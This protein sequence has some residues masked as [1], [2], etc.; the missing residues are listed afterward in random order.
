MDKTIVASLKRS[1]IKDK[2][3]K[4]RITLT[5]TE[6][7]VGQRRRHEDSKIEVHYTS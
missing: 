6:T 7:R 1:Q 4:K 3:I 5:P 2:T